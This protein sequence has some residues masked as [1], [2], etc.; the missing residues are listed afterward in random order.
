MYTRHEVELSCPVCKNPLMVEVL[1]EKEIRY[2][3]GASPAST[4]LGDLIDVNCDCANSQYLNRDWWE[5]VYLAALDKG[6]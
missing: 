2:G 5:L 3:P 1:E 4:E 6:R